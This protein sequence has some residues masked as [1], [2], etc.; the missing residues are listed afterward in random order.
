MTP[1]RAARAGVVEEDFDQAATRF[2]RFCDTD[3]EGLHQGNFRFRS[4]ALAAWF[5]P[6][7]AVHVRFSLGKWLWRKPPMESYA[8]RFA[9]DDLQTVQRK[10]LPQRLRNQHVRGQETDDKCQQLDI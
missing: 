2:T 1:F 9:P 10:P 6:V 5:R 8:A 4:G 7:G 3:C